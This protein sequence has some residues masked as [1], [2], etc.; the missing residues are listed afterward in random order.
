[1]RKPPRR[2]IIKRVVERLLAP[3]PD[4]SINVVN[5]A[6]VGDKTKQGERQEHEDLDAG[7]NKL[8]LA[9]TELIATS[10]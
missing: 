4:A 8:N 6:D 7:K 5:A 3:I 1:M 2:R 9:I 10:L